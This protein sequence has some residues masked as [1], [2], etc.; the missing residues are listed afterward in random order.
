MHRIPDLTIPDLTSSNITSLI[1]KMSCCGDQEFGTIQAGTVSSLTH[2]HTTVLIGV[3]AS[4]LVDDMR[5][6]HC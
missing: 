5:E 4:L 1:P 2:R 6:L 3:E